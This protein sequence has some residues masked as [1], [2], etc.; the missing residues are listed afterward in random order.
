[1][2]RPVLGLLEK[3][4]ISSR[5]IKAKIDTGA[6]RSSIDRE[7]AKKLKLGPIV[8]VQ[9][10]RSS[11]GRSV[12]PIIFTRVQLNGKFLKVKFNVTDRKRMRYKVLIGNNIL[13]LGGFLVD[14][15]R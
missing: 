2:K 3:V 1:M 13:K 11:H 4:K 15:L 12:R 6:D 7:L 10:V 14:P 9:G 5:T 8:D